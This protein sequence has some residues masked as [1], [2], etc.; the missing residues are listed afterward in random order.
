[1]HFGHARLVHIFG[2]FVAAQGP[3]LHAEVHCDSNVGGGGGG[4]GGA[5]FV[6]VWWWWWWWRW[7]W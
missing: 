5:R 3:S 1:M 2:D 7:S 4:G 6:V